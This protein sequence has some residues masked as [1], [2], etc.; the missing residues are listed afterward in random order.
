[1]NETRYDWLSDRWVIFAPNREERPDQYRQVVPT[2][3]NELIECPFCCGH[4]HETPNPTLVLPE[5]DFDETSS[6]RKQ[7]PSSRTRHP[8]QVRV[9][10]NKFPAIP[11][12]DSGRLEST[13]LDSP[14]FEIHHRLLAS[15]AML[16]D[17]DGSV[18]VAS[19]CEVQTAQAEHL[20]QRNKPRGAHEV[21]IESPIH[22]D[23]ITDL[24]EDHVS[25]ILEA[26]RRRLNHWRA[27]RDLKYAVVFKNY[28]SDAGAS[29]YHSHSQ[30]ISL[31]FVPRD[32]EKVNQRL[33]LHRQKYGS[34]YICQVMNEEEE[35][36]ERILTSTEHFVALC[37]FASRF[38]YSFSIIPRAHKSRYEEITETERDDLAIV[39]KRTL[40]ALE[41]A[42]PSAAYNFVLQTSPFT[43]GHED[44]YH[45]RLRI[46]PRLS[47]VAGFE[48]G[49]DC[50]INTV[51]P[52]QAASI[53]RAHLL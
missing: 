47:K 43:G 4:E 34:C 19:Q 48:W 20:F 39:V 51:T 42:Q 12:L 30:L 24:D 49:S 25:L 6:N 28:G 31:D 26:Y 29:L 2:A 50:F 22:V 45:W 46:I 32:I 37:P 44:S 3:A 41:S 52:E 53:L 10:P 11:T 35:R 9:V 16:S 8:W 18:Y 23:S 40:A 13:Q 1:M 38:P 27:Q 14:R 36:Q 5:N 17:V 15:N 33:V 21:I 7:H